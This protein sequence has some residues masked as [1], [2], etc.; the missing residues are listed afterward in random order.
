MKSGHEKW[1]RQAAE[2]IREDGHNGWGNTCEQ[3]ADF[4]AELEKDRDRLEWMFKNNAN[5][6]P[7]SETAFTVFW[8]DGDEV[9]HELDVEQSSHRNAIDAAMQK[10]AE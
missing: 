5:V 4:I 3:A 10:E 9:S 8:W 1:L 6:A 7:F 2:E